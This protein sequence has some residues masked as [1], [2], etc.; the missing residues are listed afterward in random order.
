MHCDLHQSQTRLQQ[1]T[2]STNII[3]YLPYTNICVYTI[4]VC[5]FS[6]LLQPSLTVYHNAEQLIFSFFSFI[7]TL[8][9]PMLVTHCGYNEGTH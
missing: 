5:W 6:V 7:A 2:K 1:H 9:K 8:K 3:S 4:D